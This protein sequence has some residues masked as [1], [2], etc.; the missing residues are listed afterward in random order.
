MPKKKN[1]KPSKKLRIANAVCIIF[2]CCGIAVIAYCLHGLM[3]LYGDF[4]Y[5]NRLNHL[6]LPEITEPSIVEIQIT[7]INKKPIDLKIQ[8]GEKYVQD[9]KVQ[10]DP[11]NKSI[12]VTFD[13]QTASAD[14]MLSLLPQD[15][16]E[17]QYK[18]TQSPSLLYMSNTVDFYKDAYGDLWVDLTPSYP[19]IGE[20]K[21]YCFITL[22][23]DGYAPTIYD[24]RMEQNKLV[25]LNLSE[26]IRTKN[27]D[28]A[29]C[30]EIT[31][32]FSANSKIDP[33]GD[34]KLDNMNMVSDRRNLRLDRWPKY[35]SMIHHDFS[36]TDTINYMTNE[37]YGSR[38]KESDE[39][40]EANETTSENNIT[41]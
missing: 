31:V 8:N 13:T 25:S 33:N 40:E 41:E 5:Q 35:D 9:V 4:Q 24:A 38:P 36:L 12:Y 34:T 16:Y 19:Y 10:E 22:N 1:N 23:G 7:Y 6:Q 28:L 2:V 17:L 29:K 30:R 21:I 15:N 27:I 14:Y 3:P 39:S 11:D 32:T 26:L 37:R 20:E 18:I